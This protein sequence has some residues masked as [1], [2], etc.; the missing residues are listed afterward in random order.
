MK[1]PQFL[2]HFVILTLKNRKMF[3]E[4]M[5]IFDKMPFCMIS[6]NKFIV[7]FQVEWLIVKN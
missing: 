2:R 4:Y 5:T 7:I 6:V 1:K 3:L